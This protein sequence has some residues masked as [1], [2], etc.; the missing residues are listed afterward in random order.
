M[1]KVN[2]TAK[3]EADLTNIHDFIALDNPIR[4]KTYISELRAVSDNLKTF[5][6]MGQEISGNPNHRRLIH[7]NYNLQNYRT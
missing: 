3:A 2:Y 4:A 1:F 6:F 7:E 5:P